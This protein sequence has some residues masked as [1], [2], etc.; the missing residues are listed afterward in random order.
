MPQP[1][2]HINPPR[3]PRSLSFIGAVGAID[4]AKIAHE[5]M[6]AGQ[7][8]F[9][10]GNYFA[11][12]AQ[13]QRA[14]RLQPQDVAA[15]IGFAAA[16]WRAGS[17]DVVEPT[18]QS[19]LKLDPNSCTAHEMLSQWHLLKGQ[20]DA[21]GEHITRAAAIAPT[22]ADIAV[23]LAFVLAGS[24]DSSGAWKV[25]EPLLDRSEL[26]ERIAIVYAQ[27]ARDMDRA[28]EAAEFGIRHLQTSNVKPPERRRLLFELATL[29]DRLGRYDQAFDLAR[30]ARE[31]TNVPY[32]PV[33]HSRAIDNVIANFSAER[34][35][36]LPRAAGRSDR[37]VFIVGM[38]RSG[39]SLVEQ[40]LSCHPDV[41]AAG[42]LEDLIHLVGTAKKAGSIDLNAMQ[43][44][45]LKTVNSLNTTAKRFTD[46]NPLNYEH[47]GWIELIFPGARIIH[48]RRDPLDTCL[49]CLMTDIAAGVTFCQSQRSL[50]SY[51]QDYLRVMDHW[52][53]VLTAPMLEVSY[54][55]LVT[56]L[57]SQTRRLLAFLELPWNER[58]LEFHKSA[59]GV[60]SASRDQVRKPLYTSSI[61]RWKH[62]ERHLSPL[63]NL[64]KS[65][66]TGQR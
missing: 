54:E 64:L 39:S 45:Y 62:Y 28:G 11:A 38:P 40:I 58:C 29:L 55:S 26:R 7:L 16:S 31:L 27:I 5:A 18:L 59:R 25:I 60:G 13:F 36:S 23:S 37:L 24:G 51:Y 46:K 43:A 47:L 30:Q 19:A 42:E 52:R 48:C 20:L 8:L 15:H 63:I 3:Q 9:D 34:F 6:H 22:N 66:A 14:M 33:D 21:A 49:S 10:Q 32:D 12:A 65:T 4:P 56:D 17:L 35:A 41:Y 50:A 53:K 44:G 57:E 2:E 61:G 1:F